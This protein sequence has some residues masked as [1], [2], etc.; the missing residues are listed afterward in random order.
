MARTKWSIE[1][2]VEYV[3]RA[4]EETRRDVLAV[5]VTDM[6]ERLETLDSVELQSLAVRFGGALWE[7][8]RSPTALDAL[9]TAVV[10]RQ[11]DAEVLGLPARSL[12]NVLLACANALSEGDVLP[13]PADPDELARLVE[14]IVRGCRDDSSPLNAGFMLSLVEPLLIGDRP[15]FRNL[16]GALAT[17]LITL[18]T[19]ALDGRLPDLAQTYLYWDLSNA[20]SVLN[21]ILSASRP[22]RRVH[23]RDNLSLVQP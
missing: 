5:P 22:E 12:L 4:A 23:L 16:L 14:R 1:D 2:V 20:Q 18:D 11:G 10:E 21:G 17:T 13:S 15:R 6:L 8:R 19:A 9:R 7:T 3:S